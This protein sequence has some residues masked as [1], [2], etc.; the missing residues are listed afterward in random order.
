M[1]RRA[2]KRII[3]GMKTT[4][5]RPLARVRPLLLASLTA[6]ASA[7]ATTDEG[8]R[9]VQGRAV[10]DFDRIEVHDSTDLHVQV[11]AP[12]GLS[13]RGPAA[14][15]GELSTEV[16]DGTLH[17]RRSAPPERSGP[18]SD[19]A[20]DVAVTMPSLAGLVS[21]GCGD[22]RIEG[23]DGERLDLE[24]AGSGDVRASGQVE[25]LQVALAGSGE[26]ELADL[27][28]R[29]ASVRLTGSGR[30]AVR[31]REEADVEVSGSGTVSLHG[32]PPL[33]RLVR[34]GSGTFYRR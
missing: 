23:L 11:G 12:L 4:S 7:C 14:R 18:L 10:P 29:K 33:T 13:V 2:G 5:A 25:R 26:L 15:L 27:S 32:R 31:A 1:I 30:A 24:A 21:H 34:T 22:A 19:F 28:A 17:V 9:V 20:C 16:V 3:R 8:V 6:I